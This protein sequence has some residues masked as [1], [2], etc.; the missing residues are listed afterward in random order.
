M[1]SGTLL[2]IVTFVYGLAAF[3][4]VASWVFKKPLA[5]KLASWVAVTGFIGNSAGIIMRWVESYRLGIGHAPLSNMYESLI[6]FAWTLVLI[7]LIS[8]FFPAKACPRT[9]YLQHNFIGIKSF[10]WG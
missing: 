10:F 2:S 5:G 4:Y 9:R 8:V 3:L 1:D 6:F 7:Y